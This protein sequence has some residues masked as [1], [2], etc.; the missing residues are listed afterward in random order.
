MLPP[1]CARCGSPLP[2]VAADPNHPEWCGACAARALDAPNLPPS[3][4]SASN[5]ASSAPWNNPTTNTDPDAVTQAVVKTRVLDGIL[6]GIAASAIA[7]FAWWGA[8]TAINGATESFELWHLGS[9]LVGLIIGYGVLLGA[10]R[11]GLVSGLLALVLTAATVLVAVYFIERSQT[12]ISLTDAGRT[13]D[14]PLWQGIS[15]FTDTYWSW[16]DFDRTRPLMWLL[17][18]LVAVLVAGWPGRRPPGR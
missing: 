1:S 15:G 12:I 7:G 2:A 16:W 8:T 4:P 14:V 18:P 10:R 17:G 11:G 6:T 13:S 5:R 3:V 9:A